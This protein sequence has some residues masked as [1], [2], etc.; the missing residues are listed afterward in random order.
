MIGDELLLN[1]LYHLTYTLSD[2]EKRQDFYINGEWAGFYGIQDVQTQKMNFGL[3]TLIF[4]FGTEVR[5]E[6][7]NSW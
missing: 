1:K 6:A 7:R 3:C 2:S 5:I 4:G